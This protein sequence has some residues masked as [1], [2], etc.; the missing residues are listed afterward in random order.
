M[1]EHLLDEHGETVALIVSVT[2]ALIGFLVS[3]ASNVR[4]QRAQAQYAY[5]AS[6]LQHLYGPLYALVLS[7]TASYMAFRKTF[8]PNKPLFDKDDPLTSEEREI[9]RAWAEHVFVPSN[10]RI[11][12]VIERHA[13]LVRGNSMPELFR[14]MLA[15]VESSKLVLPALADGQL[16]LLDAFPDW[17]K[18]FEGYVTEEYLAVA[19]EHERLLGRVSRSWLARR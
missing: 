7:N 16:H 13:H 18:E 6:Q 5:V 11:R 8:R 14:T 1:L 4:R 2:L 17:P 15:H 9:W 19:E 12:D 3:H 10:L